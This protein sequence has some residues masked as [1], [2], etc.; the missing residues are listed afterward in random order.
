MTR[1]L[2]EHWEFV[3]I[4]V[5]IVLGAL[6]SKLDN[7]FPAMNEPAPDWVGPLFLALPVAAVA[8]YFVVRFFKS[9]R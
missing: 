8:I 7:I 9:R 4:G 5:L 3:A 1:W 2:R 6:L